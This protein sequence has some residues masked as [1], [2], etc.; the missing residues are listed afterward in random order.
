MP[1]KF[2]S[3]PDTKFGQG[4]IRQWHPGVPELGGMSVKICGLATN[5]VPILGLSYIVEL[6]GP[7][8]SYP[9]SHAV[10]FEAHLK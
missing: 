1:I 2:L 9:Y 7:V 6:L 4:E 5:G 10:A 3:S 8:P